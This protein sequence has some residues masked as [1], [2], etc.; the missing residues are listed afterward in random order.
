MM[1]RA[2]VLILVLALSLTSAWAQFQGRII[3]RIQD[4]EGNPL[5]KVEVTIVSQRTA[6]VQYELRTDPQGRFLQIGL[7]PGYYILNFKKAGFVPGATEVRV[8][9][10]G[11]QVVD[12]TMKSLDA[13][14]EKAYSEADKLF[15]QANKLFADQKFSE[16]ASAYEKAIELDPGNWAYRLNFGLTHKKANRSEEALEA[17]RKAVELN[18]ESY[19]ANKETGET[20]ARAGRF[21]EAK[22]F[23]EKAVGLSPDDPDAHFN[24]GV[25]LINTGESEAAL[26]HFQKTVELKPDYADAYYQT[27]TI[28]IGQNRVPEARAA[29]EKFVELAPDHEQAGIARQLLEFLKK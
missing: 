17:F 23:Y 8:G 7:M 25:C 3:G 4:P 18:P 6:A 27:G 13:P 26:E 12:F 9:V 29:L 1:K 28:L 24:L 20:L 15:L 14:L 16:A 21:A 10:A 2:F 22:P 19:S 11:E 5:E